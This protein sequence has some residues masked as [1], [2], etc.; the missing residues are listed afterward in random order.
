MSLWGFGDV[1]VIVK[2]V[3]KLRLVGWSSGIFTFR[4]EWLELAEWMGLIKILIWR[5]CRH[6]VRSQGSNFMRIKWIRRQTA[7]CV[8]AVV[9]K[10]RVR[11]AILYRSAQRPYAVGN[12]RNE[13]VYISTLWISFRPNGRSSRWRV[14]GVVLRPSYFASLL[15]RSDS[16]STTLLVTQPRYTIFF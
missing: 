7:S 13:G 9:A 11:N 14:V 16:D 15:E 4:A 10:Y 8:L 5:H 6:F 2:V 12:A 3:K 1:S